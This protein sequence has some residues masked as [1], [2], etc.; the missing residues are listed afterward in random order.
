MGKKLFACLSSGNRSSNAFGTAII[1]NREEAICMPHSSG[2]RS[3][4]AFGTAIIYNREEAICMPHSSGNRSSYVFGTS[5]IICF[6]FNGQMF[7]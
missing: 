2:N 4:Y 3:S 5:I 1:Y 7:R 6:N